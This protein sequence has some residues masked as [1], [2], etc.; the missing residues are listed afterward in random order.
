MNNTE[1]I[2]EFESRIYI[3]VKVRVQATLD[4]AFQLFKGGVKI[5]LT[6][7]I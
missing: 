6:S 3:S 5:N 4:E 2:T 1:F 7:T